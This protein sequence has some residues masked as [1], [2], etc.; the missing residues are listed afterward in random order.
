MATWHEVADMLAARMYHQSHGGCHPESEADPDN[1][2]TCA[3]RAAYQAWETK[4]GRTHRRVR[5]QTSQPDAR[6]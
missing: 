6:T 3:D 5:A 1:C 4:S 2:P